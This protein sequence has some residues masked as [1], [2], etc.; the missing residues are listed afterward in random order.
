MI[1]T[2]GIA[3]YNNVENLIMT[4]NTIFKTMKNLKF[5]EYEIIIIDDNSIDKTK[6]KIRRLKKKNKNIKYFKNKTNLG[7]AASI[8]KAAKKGKGYYFKIMHSSNIESV[9]D[10]M[11]YV[12]NLKKYKLIIPYIIDK[13]IFFRKFVSKLCTWV[14][15][16][17]S[18]KNLKYFQSPL[19]CNRK[20][21]INFFPK[22]NMGNFFLA[23]IVF[24]LTKYYD[25]N[26]IFEFGITPKFKE[27]S[28]AVSYKNLISFVKT[29]ISI[30]IFRIKNI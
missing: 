12:K 29:I 6:D 13:R 28:T 4:L 21:F 17:V 22:K 27:G 5:T 16:S 23:N 8:L 1:I 9:N 26:L 30:L 15:N 18:G 2:F 19:A 20:K 10:L 25:K 24:K 7:F 11:I 3:S 14:L